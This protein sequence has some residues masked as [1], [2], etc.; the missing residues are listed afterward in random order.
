M[1]YDKVLHFLG[2]S[3]RS[4]YDKK[5][6][7]QDFPDEGTFNWK[8]VKLK[9]PNDP[10]YNGHITVGVVLHDGNFMINGVLFLKNEYEI[11]DEDPLN[12]SK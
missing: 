4:N 10:Y 8:R 3:N 9:T 11:I 2:E 5:K 1:S 12:L 7:A 6:Y